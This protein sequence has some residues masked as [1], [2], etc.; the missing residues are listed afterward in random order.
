MAHLDRFF[1]EQVAGLGEPDGADDGGGRG[2]VNGRVV[3]RE[4]GLHVE[5]LDVGR[6]GGELCVADPGD[7]GCDGDLGG[8]G[9]C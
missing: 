5:V 9:E 3:D 8:V 6:H 1:I 7:L 4:R 2:L